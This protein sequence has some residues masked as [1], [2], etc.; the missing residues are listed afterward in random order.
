AG[1]G[2]A[3]RSLTEIRGR[4]VGE[5]PPADPARAPPPPALDGGFFLPTAPP[6]ATTTV[7]V[8]LV[9]DPVRGFVVLDGA[10]NL[11]PV[12]TVPRQLGPNDY[13]IAL[14]PGRTYFFGVPTPQGAAGTYSTTVLRLISEEAVDVSL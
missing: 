12:R 8:R 10:D 5:P 11:R 14:P 4:R 9:T 6:P 3:S 2:V 1:A 7:R 13:E